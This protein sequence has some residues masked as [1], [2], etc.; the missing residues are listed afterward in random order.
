MYFVQCAGATAVFFGI[1]PIGTGMSAATMNLFFPGMCMFL[2]GGLLGLWAQSI[3]D[4]K[5]AN[6][7]ERKTNEVLDGGSSIGVLVDEDSCASM[8]D[9][10]SIGLV[11]W[12]LVF[13]IL[14][15]CGNNWGGFGAFYVQIYGSL[16]YMILVV[17]LCF[18]NGKSHTAKQCRNKIATWLGEISMSV[19]L[20][21]VPLME[22]FGVFLDAVAP[23]MITAE[24][25]ANGIGIGLPVWT[26]P[27]TVVL[28]Y[29]IGFAL[30]RLVAVPTRKWLRAK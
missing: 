11:L 2:S 15:A 21:H 3:K 19:Y 29:V 16:A 9:A 24:D 22:Y 26:I 7:T 12:L 14:S 18:D 1:S 10:T 30:E 27:I 8:A 25:K 13:T 28:S 6:E 4:M 20:I 17:A 23:G 5:V